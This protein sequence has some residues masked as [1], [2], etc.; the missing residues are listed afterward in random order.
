MLKA[1]QNMATSMVLCIS[2][3]VCSVSGHRT[4]SMMLK[5]TGKKLQK[6]EFFCLHCLKSMI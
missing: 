4:Q 5:D 1:T 2:G 3:T 6:S